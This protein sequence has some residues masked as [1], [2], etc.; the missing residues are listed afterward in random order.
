VTLQAWEKKTSR[1]LDR[2][3]RLIW[4][5][6]AKNRRRAVWVSLSGAKRMRCTADAIYFDECLDRFIESNHLELPG[7][8]S[9][10]AEMDQTQEIAAIKKPTLDWDSSPVVRSAQASSP[11]PV[12]SS[13]KRVVSD[14]DGDGLLDL[15]PMAVVCGDV[16]RVLQAYCAHTMGAKLNVEMVTA[17]ATIVAQLL[18]HIQDEEDTFWLLIKVADSGIFSALDQHT[19]SDLVTCGILLARLAPEF[20]AHCASLGVPLLSGMEAE[21]AG[22]GAAASESNMIY[23]CLYC[24][25]LASEQPTVAESQLLGRIWDVLFLEGR[26]ALVAA[27]VALLADLKPP[28]GRQEWRGGTHSE[29]ERACKG[30]VATAAAAQNSDA[31]VHRLRLLLP[32]VKKVSIYPCVLICRTELISVILT[33]LRISGIGVCAC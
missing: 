25:M 16:R 22:S 28:D 11:A 17:M 5:G 12:V 33:D 10:S 7:V 3:K 9:G 24:T 6:V 13:L 4:G 21:V 23:R 29:L 20:V 32:R 1:N 31:F 30:A 26:A 18:K 14:E 27:I 15:V 8:G 19:A 2:L